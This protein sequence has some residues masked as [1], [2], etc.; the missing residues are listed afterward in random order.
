MDGSGAEKCCRSESTAASS[1][2]SEMTMRMRWV[3]T[4]EEVLFVFY[5]SHL[6]HIDDLEFTGFDS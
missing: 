1:M 2:N 3:P 6:D 5:V 4:E